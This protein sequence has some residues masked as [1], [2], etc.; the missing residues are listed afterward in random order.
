[1]YLER[2][3]HH[4]Y[5]GGFLSWLPQFFDGYYGFGGNFAWMGMHLWYLLVLPLA[6]VESLLNPD[7]I[8]G[9]SH[10]TMRKEV[11]RELKTV[12]VPVTKEELVV[13][14]NGVEAARIPIREER[15]DLSVRSV[16]LNEVSVYQREWEE[17]R[18]IQAVLKKE[19]ARVETTG[20][21][22]SHSGSS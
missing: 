13:E 12:T 22:D 9:T 19:V 7:S 20:S 2:P 4:Q 17:N 14:K 11:S 18:E 1:M 8:L 6:L 15:V 16:P 3:S 21:A 10:V 5:A